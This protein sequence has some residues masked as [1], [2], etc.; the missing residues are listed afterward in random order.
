MDTDVNM[1]TS[2][3]AIMEAEV[4]HTYFIFIVTLKHFTHVLPLFATTLTDTW[5][6]MM[7][8]LLQDIHQSSLSICHYF[9]CIWIYT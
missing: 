6:D 7:L 2:F 5:K 9:L 1:V 8:Y 4:R 3:P